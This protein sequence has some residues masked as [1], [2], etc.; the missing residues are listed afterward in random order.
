VRQSRLMQLT[1]RFENREFRLCE[2]L[3]TVCL[4]DTICE[5]L[6]IN[7]EST[8]EVLA[9]KHRRR[10][11]AKLVERVQANVLG[12]GAVGRQLGVEPGHVGCDEGG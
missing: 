4:D 7:P 12:E 5:S 10:S 2:G 11:L 9:E 3:L 1:I 8:E 6:K